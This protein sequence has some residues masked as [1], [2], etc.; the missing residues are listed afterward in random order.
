MNTRQIAER[1]VALCR[2][3]KWE[4]AQAEL[5]ATDAVSIEPYPTPE[6]DQETKGLA[7]IV[8]KGRKFTAMV[9]T[10]HSIS[11]SDPLVATGSFAC[12]MQMDVSMKGQSRMNMAE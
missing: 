6:F 7:A 3:Q 2:E 8:E 4:Q 11:V 10:M 12:T 5:F 1:L 9:E